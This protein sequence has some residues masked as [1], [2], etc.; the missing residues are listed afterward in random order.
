MIV[1]STLKDALNSK[2]KSLR[3]NQR[4][5]EMKVLSLWGESVGIALAKQTKAQKMING[6]LY[7][8]VSSSV[9]AHQLAFFK[10][11]YID[12]IN[13][14]IGEPLVKDIFFQVG[15]IQKKEEEIKIEKPSEYPPVTL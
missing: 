10:N 6:R 4:L 13:R 1:L 8:T 12:R 15:N 2:L 9:W 3:V 14:R 7:I 5:A 11:D